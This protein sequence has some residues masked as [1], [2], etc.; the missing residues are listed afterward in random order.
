MPCHGPYVLE[1]IARAK[2]GCHVPAPCTLLTK[3]QHNS[4]V[5]SRGI[6]S[7]RKRKRPCYVRSMKKH[8]THGSYVTRQPDCCAEE[9]PVE[10]SLKLLGVDSIR[11]SDG[12]LLRSPSS[13]RVNTAGPQQAASA[14]Q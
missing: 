3:A 9:I 1:L 12:T 10:R 14:Q 2:A 6:Q 7:G 8:A 5:A 13:A 11:Q 4:L